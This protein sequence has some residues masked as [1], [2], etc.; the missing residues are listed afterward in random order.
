METAVSAPAVL[1]GLASVWQGCTPAVI[2][3][4][5]PPRPRLRQGSEDKWTYNPYKVCIN[6]YPSKAT[7][8]MA[9]WP[10]T[11]PQVDLAGRRPATWRVVPGQ[12]EGGE[13]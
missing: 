10:I 7:L 3:G 1:W 12:T 9:Q 8:A 6:P 11:G 13:I 4:A 2:P 5:A